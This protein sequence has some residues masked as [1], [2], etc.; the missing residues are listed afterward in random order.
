MVDCR[1]ILA[2]RRKASTAMNTISLDHPWMKTLIA[3]GH[4]M[5]IPF[6]PLSARRRTNNSTAEIAGNRWVA[7]C[8]LRT[9]EEIVFEVDKENKDYI[10]GCLAKRSKTL[11]F[12]WFETGDGCLV[13][14]NL[15]ATDAVGWMSGDVDASVRSPWKR[16]CV[17]MR[18]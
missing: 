11:H 1:V 2:L 18:F 15:A 14:I 10:Y 8:H 17:V 3:R 7:I 13:G 4:R 6:T 12:M 9:G 16:D 5:G